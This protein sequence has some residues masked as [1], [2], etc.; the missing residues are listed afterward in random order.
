MNDNEKLIDRFFTAFSNLDYK[1][2]QDCYADNVIF[3]DPAFGVL[4]DDEV[5]KMWEMLCRRAKDFS[6]NYYNIISEDEYG[7]CEWTATYLFSLT[8]RRVT[9]QVKSYMK[10]EGGKI[11]EHSD[12]FS[13][14]KWSAQALGLK[15]KLFGWSGSFQKKLQGRSR[16]RLAE[17]MKNK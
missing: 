3:S 4:Y 12:A 14:H 1:T 15:G 5:R 7:T 16:A 13:L 2:M 10:M 8:G 9:N 11:I 6:L 17:F